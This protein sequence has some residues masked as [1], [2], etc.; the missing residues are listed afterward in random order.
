M[1]ETSIIQEKK[2]EGVEIYEVST[3]NRGDISF[4]SSMEQGHTVKERAP[5]ISP[6]EKKLV[7]KINLAFV[8]LVCAILFV[9][10]YTFH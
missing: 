4:D 6:E 7:K 3:S 10:V 9:Q 1:T 2:Q 5:E 8:P